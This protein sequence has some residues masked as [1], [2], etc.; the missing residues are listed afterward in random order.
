MLKDIDLGI[1]CEGIENSNEE[2]IVFE[3]GCD[4]VQGFLYDKPIKVSEFKNKYL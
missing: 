2:Q 4:E 1:I 3:C